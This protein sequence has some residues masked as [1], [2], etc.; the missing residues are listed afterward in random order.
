MGSGFAVE[1]KEE[2]NTA[3]VQSVF[4]RSMATIELDQR[5]EIH[6]R[7][8]HSRR[9]EATVYPTVAIN[10]TLDKWRDPLDRRHP[11]GCIPSRC[12]ERLGPGGLAG[13]QIQAGTIQDEREAQVAEKGD[14]LATTSH[15]GFEV[16]CGFRPV[17]HP[18]EPISQDQPVRCP[19]S[20]PSILN[21]CIIADFL[22]EEMSS[23]AFD[24]YDGRI[25]KE[26]ISS[27]GA[28]AK[29]DLLVVKKGGTN[30]EKVGVGRRH[31]SAPR[32]RPASLSATEE[33]ILKLPEECKVDGDRTAGS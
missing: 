21:V 13:S 9:I 7:S 2:D 23:I 17:E 4:F 1:R 32:T 16:D 10:A 11:R 19:L 24:K 8:D 14:P 5:S 6:H 28:P 12:V 22:I 26:R 30:L 3:V 18:V 31:K 29:A 33:I 25:W 15:R 27:T 20:E